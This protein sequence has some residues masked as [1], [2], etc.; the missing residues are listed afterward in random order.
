MFPICGVQEVFNSKRAALSKVLGADNPTDLLTKYTDKAVLVKA[1]E[2]MGLK[3]MSGRSAMA[4]AAMGTEVN[5]TALDSD[6][7]KLAWGHS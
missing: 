4:P 3:F 1:V 6:I 2:N 5:S 7:P